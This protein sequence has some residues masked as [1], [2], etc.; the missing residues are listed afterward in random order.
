MLVPV[1]CPNCK[2]ARDL[3]FFSRVEL[4]F[5]A[6]DVAD[7]KKVAVFL[8]LI[9]SKTYSLLRN[10]VSPTRPQEKLYKDLVEVLKAHYEP[11]HIV[12]AERF[13]FHRR[14]QAGGE[15][16]SEYLAEL[17]RLSTHCEFGAY[18]KEALRDR[19]VCGLRSESIQKKLLTVADLSLAEAQKLSLRM[20][21]AEKS[22]KSLKNHGACSEQS[23]NESVLSMWQNKSRPE[24]VSFQR[25]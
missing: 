8:S 19:L 3:S 12:I 4:F 6:N 1:T 24:R 20:E 22:A 13:H 5:A 16:I 9:G 25:R 18:L 23:I 2:R 11:K 14:A 21:A 7:E 15:S 17:R 10:L